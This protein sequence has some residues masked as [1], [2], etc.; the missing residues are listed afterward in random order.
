[1]KNVVLIGFMGTGK[2]SAGRALAQRLGRAFVDLDAK[3]E[4][5]AG[6]FA[7]EGEAAFRAMEKEM[8][9]RMASRR[10]LVIATGGGTVKDAANVEALRK[11]GAIVCL[12]ASVDA[13]LART[14]RVGDRPVLDQKDAGDRRRAVEDLM[15]ER[16][17]LY[18]VADYCV[19][20]SDLSP[21]QVVDEI[22][23]YLKREGVF[24]A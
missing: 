22:V 7:R 17:A 18:E 1:M 3:I 10:A 14:A 4:K 8:V 11:N 23:G 12:T 9:K 24:R 2:T 13:V 6:R 15:E 19:D 20:T 16:R 21:L 5:E